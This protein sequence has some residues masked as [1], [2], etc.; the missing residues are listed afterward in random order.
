[1]RSVGELKKYVTTGGFERA[2]HTD[3]IPFFEIEWRVEVV[4]E[5]LRCFW[6]FIIP[7][8]GKFPDKN[9]WS[10]YDEKEIFLEVHTDSTMAR[11]A[12][13]RGDKEVQKPT[14]KE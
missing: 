9:D 1:M 13:R 11:N 6:R 10:K 2:F 12:A 14:Q 8:R 4:Y 3:G 5:G 7:D